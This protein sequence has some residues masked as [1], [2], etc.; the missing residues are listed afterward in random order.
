MRMRILLTFFTFQQ[1]SLFETH[2][3]M[4][5]SDRIKNDSS[6]LSLV[7]KLR[8]E[9]ILSHNYTCIHTICFSKTLKLWITIKNYNC[10]C[11]LKL[12]EYDDK[13]YSLWYPWNLPRPTLTFERV[14][15][16]KLSYGH[17]F[18]LE[19]FTIRPIIGARW[20]R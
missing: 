19:D 3:L 12:Y 13:A 17:D 9:N 16:H 10:M 2:H 20:V 18:I 7:L 6:C 15:I 8:F 4:L 14:Q 1:L 11:T 5:T